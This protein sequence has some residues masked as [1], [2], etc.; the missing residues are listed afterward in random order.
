MDQILQNLA[1]KI[2]E[3]RRR[4]K[5]T[6]QQ[7]AKEI[8]MSP[9]LVSQVER[10]ML[11]PSL[12]TLLRIAKLFEVSPGYLLDDEMLSDSPERSVSLVRAQERKSLLTQGNIKFSLLSKKFDLGSEFIL[13]EYPPDSSTGQSR[14]A[15]EGVECGL[16]LQG[17][18]EVEIEDRAYH[19]K[20]GDS[21]TYRSS[22]PHRTFN[23][24]AKKAR[25]V[26][27]NSEPFIFSVK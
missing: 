23:R 20:P 19:L 25:A 11:K 27:V 5:L 4:R 15:H 18:L 2:R 26:W 10:G 22:S 24:S 6:L 3:L 12:E 14:H 1:K 17:E 7:M 13:I 9:S 16:L 8:A 21:I